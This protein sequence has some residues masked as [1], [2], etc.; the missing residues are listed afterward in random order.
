MKEEVL[1]IYCMQFDSFLP[2]VDDLI[3]CYV[4]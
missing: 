2:E 3:V 1:P 4:H